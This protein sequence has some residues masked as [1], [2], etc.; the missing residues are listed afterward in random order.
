MI[1]TQPIKTVNRPSLYQEVMQFSFLFLFALVS[2]SQAKW[3]HPVEAVARIRA[4]RYGEPI[5][6]GAKFAASKRSPVQSQPQEE[7]HEERDAFPFG[8]DFTT[9]T[10]SNPKAAQYTVSFNR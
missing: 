8:K 10:F 1:P 6:S 2:A 7:V 3:V 4:G 9:P 5:P